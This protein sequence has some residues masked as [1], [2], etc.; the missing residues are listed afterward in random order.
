MRLNYLK[1]TSSSSYFTVAVG[2]LTGMAIVRFTLILLLTTLPALL[3]GAII[4]LIAKKRGQVLVYAYPVTLVFLLA[5]KYRNGVPAFSV[6]NPI[7]P[8]IQWFYLEKANTMLTGI[9][10][11]LARM[12]VLL[13]LANSLVLIIVLKVVHNIK[14]KR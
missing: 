10:E 12:D 2:N 11:T 4:G 7:R 13:L 8:F 9:T 14:D 1:K 6:I 3:I 5:F